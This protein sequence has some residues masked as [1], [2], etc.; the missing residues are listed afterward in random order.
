MGLEFDGQYTARHHS[1]YDDFYWMNHSGDPGYRYHTVDV[2]DY[3]EFADLQTPTLSFCRGL[4]Q[5]PAAI[6]ARDGKGQDLA[7]LD[8][9]PIYKGV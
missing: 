2:A 9:Q 6:C 8:L 7:S 1:M 5:Q 3:G 4:W